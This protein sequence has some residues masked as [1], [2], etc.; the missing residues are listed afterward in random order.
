MRGSYLEIIVQKFMALCPTLS[1]WIIDLGH[2]NKTAHTLKKKKKEKRK[3]KKNCPRF[4]LV[5]LINFFIE[6][7]YVFYVILL[8]LFYDT[9]VFPWYL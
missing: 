6:I 2:S 3:K 8:D 1:L 4:G 7:N 9:S 5:K